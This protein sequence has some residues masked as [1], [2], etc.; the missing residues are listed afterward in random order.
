[1]GTSSPTKKK[2][3]SHISV[4]RRLQFFPL[5]RHISLSYII[6]P[7][8]LCIFYQDTGPASDFQESSPPV[9]AQN[10]Q[11]FTSEPG[12]ASVGFAV[13]RIIRSE[14]DRKSVRIVSHSQNR[15]PC[16]LRFELLTYTRKSV[17]IRRPIFGVLG[18]NDS[19]ILKTVD[20][21]T[22]SLYLT[23]TKHFEMQLNVVLEPLRP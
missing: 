16:G 2:F 4:S 17:T 13:Y 23:L 6:S 22:Y 8:E 7:T 14:P 10:R 3:P 9:F 18:P 1:M 5:S 21:P 11:S 15:N 12:R 20:L 19:M